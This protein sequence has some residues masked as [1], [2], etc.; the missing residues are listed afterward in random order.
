MAR[1]RKTSGPKPE[2]S[3]LAAQVTQF[4]ASIGVGF[5]FD[6]LGNDGSYLDPTTPLFEESRKLELHGTFIDPRNAE[7]ICLD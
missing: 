1:K 4:D 3:F 6:L 5:N 2:Y 7:A